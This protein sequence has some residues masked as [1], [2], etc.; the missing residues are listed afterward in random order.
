MKRFL[1]YLLISFSL[2][3]IVSCGDDEKGDDAPTT[4]TITFD[5]DGGSEVP[6]QNVVTMV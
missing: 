3:S 4:Y 1:F 5:T 2:L 6:A